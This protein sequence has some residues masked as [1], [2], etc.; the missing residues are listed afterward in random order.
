MTMVAMVA[1]VIERAAPSLATLATTGEPRLG[2]IGTVGTMVPTGVGRRAQRDHPDHPRTIVSMSRATPEKE[3]GKQRG[4]GCVGAGRPVVCAP[5]SR[6]HGPDGPDGPAARSVVLSAPR[7]LVWG[8]GPLSMGSAAPPAGPRRRRWVSLPGPCRPM[9]PYRHDGSTGFRIPGCVAVTFRTGSPAPSTQRWTFPCCAAPSRPPAP[10][11]RSR[12]A[13]TLN[14]RESGGGAD[15]TGRSSRRRGHPLGRSGCRR[16]SRSTVEGG[17]GGHLEPR[18]QQAAAT[19]G[20]IV[21]LLSACF[22]FHF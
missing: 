10:R 11:A 2:T 17:L 21:P 19:T 12:T 15:P 3:K 1:Q 8:F 4:I 9:V 14:R 6:D 20:I 22:R 13:R 7:R 18:A 5:R 16:G